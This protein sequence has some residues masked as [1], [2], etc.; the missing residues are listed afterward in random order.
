MSKLKPS[1]SN[2]QSRK[3]TLLDSLKSKFEAG[4]IKRKQHLANT[5]DCK[6]ENK[7]PG[8]SPVP[9]IFKERLTPGK[10]S[11]VITFGWRHWDDIL[12]KYRPVRLHKGGGI[13]NIPAVNRT[14]NRDN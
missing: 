3:Q 4:R 9:Y 13:R 12:K 6:A 5:N 10:M 1:D 2:P 7:E 11:K 14:K 8:I